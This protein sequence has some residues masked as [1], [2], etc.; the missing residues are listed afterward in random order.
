MG[1]ITAIQNSLLQVQQLQNQAFG[2][3]A[4]ALTIAGPQGIAQPA[5]T[6]L[7]PTPVLGSLESLQIQ[8]QNPTVLAANTVQ[9]NALQTNAQLGLLAPGKDL[10][11][12]TSQTTQTNPAQPLSQS[13]ILP[14]NV[15]QTNLTPALGTPVLQ[16]AVPPQ[17]API[18]PTAQSLQNNLVQQTGTPVFQVP[19]KTATTTAAPTAQPATQ[20]NP[21]ETAAL[22][23]QTQT[24]I[25]LSTNVIQLSFVQAATGA[26]P[27]EAEIQRRAA[28]AGATGLNP[29]T[30]ANSIRPV[31]QNPVNPTGTVANQPIAAGGVFAALLPGG[32]IPPAQA[33]NTLQRMGELPPA[34]QPLQINL[35]A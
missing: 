21:L 1:T 17:N 9:L 8:G 33:I 15:V 14:Q 12:Q 30:P 16:L 35:A 7:P 23:A 25:A 4:P 20:A 26:A 22:Q 10:A 29:V 24:A 18:V 13:T 19:A 31:E 32:G 34:P 2:S 5:P 3:L 27:T 6:N 11:I 28:L